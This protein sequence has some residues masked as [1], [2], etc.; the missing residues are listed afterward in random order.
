MPINGVYNIK[1]VGTVIAGNVEQGSVK[2]GDEIR[3]VSRAGKTFKVFSIER[4]HES[5]NE[6]LPGDSVGINV[7]GFDKGDIPTTGDIMCLASDTKLKLVKQFKAMVQVMDHPGE[8]RCR[9]APGGADEEK[10]DKKDEKKEKGKADKDK[11]KETKVRVRQGYTPTMAVRT[12]KGPVEMVKIV[13]K[14]GKETGGKW[15]EDAIFLKENEAAEVIFEPKGDLCVECFKDCEGLGRIAFLE[16]GQAV[17]L[18]QITN[19]TYAD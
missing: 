7:R 12:A 2:V 17:M 4:H 3:F 19:V 15:I 10:D 13:K 8:L 9:G 18:G 11:D 5:C 16:G 6:A 14:M 1:G